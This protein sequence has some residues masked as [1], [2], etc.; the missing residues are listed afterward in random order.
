MTLKQYDI[1]VFS[2]PEL[3]LS[4]RA[5]I[6]DPKAS[7]GDIADIVASD[8][9]LSARVVK[10]AGSTLTGRRVNSVRQA[11]SLVGCE[12]VM[13]LATAAAL[14]E[15]SRLV[16]RAGMD[17][18]MFWF[19]GLFAANL[20]G[21]VALKF[22]AITPE[23]LYTAALL[24]GIGHLPINLRHRGFYEMHETTLGAELARQRQALGGV[25]WL[26]FNVLLAEKYRL[27]PWMTEVI[28]RFPD[29]GDPSFNVVA[30]AW[31]V[32]LALTHPDHCHDSFREDID[33]AG[34]CLAPGYEK[35][36]EVYHALIEE[37]YWEAFNDQR[38][39][40]A[41]ESGMSERQ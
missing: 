36:P 27:S 9:A 4:L 26:D 32:A 17:I 41:S 33:A 40:M 19:R 3:M 31:Q 37:S 28:G 22:S 12:A 5:A 7:M 25:C 13:G 1:D 24:A 11:V 35:N 15:N 10:L 34:A 29:G 2:P 8:G 21:K 18:E 14:M 6:D 16:E 30:F 39:L 20:A 23:N 38:S